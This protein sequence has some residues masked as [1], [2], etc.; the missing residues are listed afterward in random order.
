MFFLTLLLEHIFNEMITDQFSNQHTWIN[1][2]PVDQPVHC[3]VLSWILSKESKQDYISSEQ[4]ASKF[5]YTT[6]YIRKILWY[7]KIKPYGDKLK[8]DTYSRWTEKHAE[9]TCTYP[10]SPYH[11]FMKIWAKFTRNIFTNHR[12]CSYREVRH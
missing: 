4:N 9:F 10:L 12:R 7:L 8:D 1:L 6:S 3:W 5:I 2:Q 11:S